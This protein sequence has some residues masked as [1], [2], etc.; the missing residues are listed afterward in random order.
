MKPGYFSIQKLFITNTKSLIEALEN[1]QKNL[2]YYAEILS[3]EDQYSTNIFDDKDEYDKDY[4]YLYSSDANTP[5][6][7]HLRDICEEIRDKYENYS[8]YIIIDD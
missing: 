8:R 4:S 5:L 2:E 1:K 6:H 3:V 7:Q